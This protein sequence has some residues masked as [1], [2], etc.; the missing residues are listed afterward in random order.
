MVWSIPAVS[1]LEPLTQVSTVPTINVIWSLHFVLQFRINILWSLRGILSCFNRKHKSSRVLLFPAIH[2]PHMW[3]SLAFS[4]LGFLWRDGWLSITDSASTT[5]ISE[6]SWYYNQWFEEAYLGIS[7]PSCSYHWYWYRSW[8]TVRKCWGSFSSQARYRG[9]RL[10]HEP[11]TTA[12][13]SE[14]EHSSFDK[15]TGYL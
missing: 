1:Y 10:P 8:W 4:L 14:P 6:N 2:L 3:S 9:W 5:A 12:K 11:R 15:C 7:V 13:H